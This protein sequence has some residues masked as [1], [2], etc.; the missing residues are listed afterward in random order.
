MSGRIQ[1]SITVPHYMAS[2]NLVPAFNLVMSVGGMTTI[3]VHALGPQGDGKRRVKGGF[4]Y[5][6]EKLGKSIGLDGGPS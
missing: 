2:C 5:S 4:G 3:A 1:I 6:V